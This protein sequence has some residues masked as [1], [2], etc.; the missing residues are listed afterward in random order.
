MSFEEYKIS[1]KHPVCE[2]LTRAYKERNI[3][4]FIE[5][6]KYHPYFN[7][8]I[9]T[10]HTLREKWDIRYIWVN[11][12]TK[13]KANFIKEIVVPILQDNVNDLYSSEYLVLHMTLNT[14][15]TK[16]N[17]EVKFTILE[18]II[19]LPEKR[20]M[21]INSYVKAVKKY[22]VNNDIKHT[23]NALYLNDGAYLKKG[24]QLYKEYDIDPDPATIKTSFYKYHTISK[25]LYNKYVHGLDKEVLNDCGVSDDEVF[26]LF[27]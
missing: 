27:D 18:I 19:D 7:K 9:F 12:D 13:M 23:M 8:A 26:D 1:R 4:Q 3:S 24:I 11:M 5:D 15:Y 20:D 14:G 6:Y 10:I 17:G 22:I 25:A 21:V 2:A 16:Y